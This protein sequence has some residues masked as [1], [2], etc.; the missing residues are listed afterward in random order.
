MKGFIRFI[1]GWLIWIA[2]LIGI[3]FIVDTIWLTHW[4]PA[5][6]W[7]HGNV[8]KSAYATILGI[9][10]VPKALLLPIILTFPLYFLVGWARFDNEG[11][12]VWSFWEA[13]DLAFFPTVAVL[14]FLMVTELYWKLLHPIN[15]VLMN[16]IEKPIEVLYFLV[17]TL[18][19]VTGNT[20]SVDDVG[21][22]IQSRRK[23]YEQQYE[24]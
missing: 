18:G 17:F 21:D 6:H 23:Q 5:D 2:V 24:Q 1:K 13:L 14:L 15:Q 8:F 19:C 11:H 7:Y 4:S 10:K 12:A 3:L 16:F 9:I 20:P 22:V